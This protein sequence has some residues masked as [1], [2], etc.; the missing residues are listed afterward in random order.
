M[1]SEAEFVLDQ[2]CKRRPEL[3][4]HLVTRLMHLSMNRNED[5]G[6]S[7]CE[8]KT[9]HPISLK[10]PEREYVLVLVRR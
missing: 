4:R 6:A 5:I 9:C 1:S 7:F 8:P 2:L 10:S 3:L